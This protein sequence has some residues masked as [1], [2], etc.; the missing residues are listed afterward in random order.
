MTDRPCPS[1]PACMHQVPRIGK[2]HKV[3]AGGAVGAAGG[4]KKGGAA[5]AA[6]PTVHD[7]MTKELGV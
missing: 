4:G 3:L 1:T 7:I 2:G 6:G 5:A